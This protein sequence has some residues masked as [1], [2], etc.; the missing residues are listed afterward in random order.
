MSFPGFSLSSDWDAEIAVLNQ[1]K[2]R[3]RFSG[4]TP[5]SQVPIS[6]PVILSPDL[7]TE[8]VVILAWFKPAEPACVDVSTYGRSAGCRS[9]QASLRGPRR[10]LHS[11]ATP[12]S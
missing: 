7:Q 5:N 3:S 10:H 12:P 4:E 2:G 6:F 9:P 8:P 1:E 11:A